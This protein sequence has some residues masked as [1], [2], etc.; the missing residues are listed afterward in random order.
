MYTIQIPL[1]KQV[2]KPLSNTILIILE[3]NNNEAQ[4]L[5]NIQRC[6]TNGTTATSVCLN[7]TSN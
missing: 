4:K 2:F 7:S 1:Y 6:L 3:S 5:W